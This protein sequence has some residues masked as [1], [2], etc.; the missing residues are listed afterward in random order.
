M[1]LLAAAVLIAIAPAAAYHGEAN[2]LTVAQMQH[3]P[4]GAHGQPA[5][6][7]E[8]ASARAFRDVNARMHRDMDIRYSG[9]ADIDFVRGM[10]PHHQGAIDMARI[11]LEHGR[12]PEV[13][14][15]A[16]EII[17]AQEAE[18]TQMREILRRLG[19]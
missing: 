13:R 15:L 4:H 5:R 17:K 3:A 12:D 16:E 6:A 11:V 8:P 7:D 19:G 10:I 1:M 9:N 2:R 14:K 18:I